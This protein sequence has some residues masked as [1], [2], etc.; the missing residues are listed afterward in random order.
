[1]IAVRIQDQQP[2]TT[3]GS[4][5]H[6]PRRRSFAQQVSRHYWRIAEQR[7]RLFNVATVIRNDP[8]L[9]PLQCAAAIEHLAELRARAQHCQAFLQ[10]LDPRM[11][12]SVKPYGSIAKLEMLDYRLTEA[13]I[14]I[15]MFAPICQ[16]IT[17]ERVILHLLIRA[18]FPAILATFEDTISQLAALV[19]RQEEAQ[20]WQ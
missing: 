2:R 4:Q 20:A 12:E 9:Y 8:Q 10:G 13:T 14:T 17:Q 19:E 5:E 1:M 7:R 16:S 11:T 3:S 15:A 6:Q 18:M